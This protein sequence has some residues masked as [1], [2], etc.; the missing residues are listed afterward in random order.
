MHKGDL[1]VIPQLSFWVAEKG[2]NLQSYKYYGQQSSLS[3]INVTKNRS[4]SKDNEN[5]IE[6]V[7]EVLEIPALKAVG[8]SI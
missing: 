1:V 5:C 8:Y 2:Y 6:T 4:F 3:I 7:M